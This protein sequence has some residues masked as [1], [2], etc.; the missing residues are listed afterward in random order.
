[1]QEAKGLDAFKKVSNREEWKKWL[2]NYNDTHNCHIEGN[3]FMD[4]FSYYDFNRCEDKQASIKQLIAFE[5]YDEFYVLKEEY[6]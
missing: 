5:E 2:E 4:R 6:C 3:F 1:M